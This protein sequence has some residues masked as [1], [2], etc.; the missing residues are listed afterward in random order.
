MTCGKAVSE[1]QERGHDV[2]FTQ[3][4]VTDGHGEQGSGVEQGAGHGEVLALTERT[5][6]REQAGDGAGEMA[7]QTVAFAEAGAQIGHGA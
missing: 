2:R 5:G 7:E 4:A 1:V 3:S 6:R